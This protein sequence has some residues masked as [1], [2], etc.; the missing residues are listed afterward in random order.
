ML[1]IASKYKK[2]FSDF[3]WKYNIE[4]KSPAIKFIIKLCRAT[5]ATL[6]DLS[7]GQITLHATSLVYTTLLSLIPL[8]ATN[9]AILKAVGLHNHIEP[10]LVKLFSPLGIQA[11]TLTTHIID[12][13]ENIQ[14]GVLGTV[15]VLFLVYTSV[16]LLNKIEHIFNK[17]WHV[18]SSQS[19]AQKINKYISVLVMGPPLVIL[20]LAGVAALT[21]SSLMQ[22][23]LTALGLS[24]WVTV[25]TKLLPYIFII[26]AFTFIYMLIPNTRVNIKPALTGAVVAGL[27]WETIGSIFTAIVASSTNYAAIYSSLAALV[28]FIIWLFLSWTIVLL[29]ANL[30][31]Y[32]QYPVNSRRGLKIS[33]FSN[34]DREHLTLSAASI[35]LKKFSE[36]A[37]PPTISDLSQQLNQTPDL[38][39][40]ILSPLVREKYIMATD[41]Q[42]KTFLPGKSPE[43][44]LI[45]DLMKVIR[46][47]SQ[48]S[49]AT[50]NSFPVVDDIMKKN[51]ENLTNTM[52]EKTL[53][54]LLD[55]KPKENKNN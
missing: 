11:P 23:T 42:P 46:G 13:V 33:D 25:I 52:N 50:E 49:Q 5:L 2:Q 19:W 39:K 22:T 45:S 35:I 4:N 20:A 28:L 51:E 48:E 53:A 40:E 37:S 38:I 54:D 30:S 31:Y 18:D 55:V 9:F 15:G 17:T 3:I 14:V 24:A 29:G 21:N 7:K 43:T 10:V 16:A 41:Q 8:F 12:T 34:Y 26:L 47:F 1:T 6:H 44:I 36:G 27:L 32:T